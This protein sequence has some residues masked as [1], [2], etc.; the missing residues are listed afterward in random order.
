MLK[1]VLFLFLLMNSVTWADSVILNTKDKVTLSGVLTS[2]EF[3]D[4]ND[5]IETVNVLIL[6]KPIS[7]EEDD[8]GGPVTNAVKMQLNF[9]DTV[10]ILDRYKKKRVKV[11]GKLF[12]PNTAHQ[13][14]EILMDVEKLV[15]VGN[16]TKK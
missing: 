12:Y 15:A 13:H 16:R 8:F 11:T 9:L 4:A 5:Q 1:K 2:E 10:K 14:T 3:P 7:T 6:D